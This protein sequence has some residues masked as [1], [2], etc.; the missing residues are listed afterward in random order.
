ME[1]YSRGTETQITRLNLY[2]LNRITGFLCV[3]LALAT[4]DRQALL[5]TMRQGKNGEHSTLNILNL[6]TSSSI[7]SINTIY[8]TVGLR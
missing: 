8:G 7:E 3:R 5:R 6:L 2:L 4:G 1:P